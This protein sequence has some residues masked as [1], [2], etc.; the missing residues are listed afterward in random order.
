V[1]RV[2]ELSIVQAGHQD[3]V[4]ARYDNAACVIY[5]EAQVGSDRAPEG[6]LHLVAD[7]DRIVQRDLAEGVV[8]RLSSA[9]RRL[10]G[11]F[12]VPLFGS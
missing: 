5:G 9:P 6:G 1:Q 11:R 7:A 2:V 10:A 12:C 3:G 4:D 8:I